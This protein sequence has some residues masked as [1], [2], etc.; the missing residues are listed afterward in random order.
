MSATVE[1][2]LGGSFLSGL[3]EELVES[4]RNIQEVS[5]EGIL[6]VNVKPSVGP[7][8]WDVA[9]EFVFVICIA[10]RG[11]NRFRMVGL[12]AESVLDL[13]PSFT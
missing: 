4:L 5:F 9:S 13:D 11:L 2:A 10:L 7:F 8:A 1:V 12:T 3:E 6:D